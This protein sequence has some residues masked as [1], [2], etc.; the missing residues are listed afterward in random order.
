MELLWQSRDLLCQGGD[1]GGEGPSP[2]QEEQLW[3][4]ERRACRPMQCP[5]R[6]D[7]GENRRQRKPA[8]SRDASV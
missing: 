8:V 5:C 4:E 1:V 3:G 6:W 7:A 2:E